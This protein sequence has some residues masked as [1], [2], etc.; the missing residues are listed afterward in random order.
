MKI[1]KIF[2]TI[3][4]IIVFILLV[5]FIF[6]GIIMN[7]PLISEKEIDLEH[8]VKNIWSIVVNNS[9]YKWRSDIK[10]IVILD[11]GK[12]WIEY[13]DVNKKYYTTFTLKEK[14]EY[15]LYSFN[16]ENK[17]F[18]GTWVGKFIEI[19][20]NQTK[21]IFTETIYMKNKIMNVLA[22]LFWNLEKIQEKY[23]IDLIKKLEE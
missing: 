20:E 1:L 14:K 21:L 9:D 2:L 5:L 16:I 15:T 23:F 22:K 4:A 10:N 6:G 3:F 19:N 7:K 13:Y 18:H 12:D 17:N 8:N 11:N